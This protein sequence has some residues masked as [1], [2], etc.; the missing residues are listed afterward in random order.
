MPAL[1]IVFGGMMDDVYTPDAAAA[2]QRFTDFAKLF[3]WLG[4]VMAC[5]AFLQMVCFDLFAEWQAPR[6]RTAYVKAILRQDATWFDTLEHGAL[7]LPGSIANDATVIKAGLGF[8]VSQAIQFPTTFLLSFVAGFIWGWQMA[9]MMAGAIP[10][11]AIVMGYSMK[12]IQES[13]KRESSSYTKA[14]GYATETLSNLRT[15]IAFGAE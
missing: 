11:L 13:Q 15:V 12:I 14:S 3:A 7:E 8:K 10:I 4:L 2:G 6:I 9:A 5:T 1:N